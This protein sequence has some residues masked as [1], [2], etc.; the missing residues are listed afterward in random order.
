MEPQGF[1]A[2][3]L[4]VRIESAFDELAMHRRLMLEAQREIQLKETH[5]K[6]ENIEK[7]VAARN[8]EVRSAMLAE[9]LQEDEE[10]WRQRKAYDESRKDFRVGLLEAKRFELLIA[11]RA[12]PE[13][14]GS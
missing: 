4:E 10:Y 14:V 8:G 7:W 3:D 6:V 13:A 5:A 9:W 12:I 1:A 11:A 2:E